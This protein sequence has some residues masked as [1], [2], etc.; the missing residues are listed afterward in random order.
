MRLSKQDLLPFQ[1]EFCFRNC[2]GRYIV[3]PHTGCVTWVPWLLPFFLPGISFDGA[4]YVI[5]NV[6]LLPS[7]N[8]YLELFWELEWNHELDVLPSNK[9]YFVFFLLFF[10]IIITIVILSVL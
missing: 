4:V 9:N 8:I 3:H 7:Q 2:E 6:L 1:Q 10:L 5:N